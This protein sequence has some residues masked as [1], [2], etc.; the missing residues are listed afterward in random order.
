MS[1]GD[2][3]MSEVEV[4]SSLLLPNHDD[5]QALSLCKGY[6]RAQ[7][8]PTVDPTDIAS[9]LF[10]YV[11]GRNRHVTFIAKNKQEWWQFSTIIFKTNKLL[12]INKTYNQSQSQPNVNQL[13]QK[14]HQYNKD[15]KNEILIDSVSVQFLQHSCL[16]SYFQANGYWFQ[17]GIIQIDKNKSKT[18]DENIQIFENVL[19]KWKQDNINKTFN[20]IGSSITLQTMRERI[21]E[22]D[23]E[24]IE[25]HTKYLNLIHS[26]TDNWVDKGSDDKLTS[27]QGQKILYLK[28]K[29]FI[30]IDLVYSKKDS[31]YSLHFY[32]MAFDKFVINNNGNINGK[33]SIDP[34]WSVNVDFE[35]YDVVYGLSSVLCECNSAKGYQF[36]VTNNMVS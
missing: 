22:L 25:I 32:N 24:D 36:V 18:S 35:V 2:L 5:Q 26:S 29:D 1:Y 14:K 8:P 9:I 10:K 3:C 30:R 16:N 33:P 28:E 11:G 15:N 17:C 21:N 34:I 31:S 12:S 23:D 6:L 20:N 19:Q 27:I 7:I 4:Q 13:Q